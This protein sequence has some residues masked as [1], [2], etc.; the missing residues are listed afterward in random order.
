LTVTPAVPRA[1]HVGA[2]AAFVSVIEYLLA[3]KMPRSHCR[4]EEADQLDTVPRYQGLAGLRRRNLRELSPDQNP[5]AVSQLHIVEA[6]L[7]RL[8]QSRT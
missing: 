3:V 2:F 5:S 4:V 1:W 6:V 7:V 8:R